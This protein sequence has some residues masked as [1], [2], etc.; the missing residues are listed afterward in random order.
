[1]LCRGPYI[2]PGGSAYGCGQCMPCR[3]NKR[4]EW[5]HRIMLEA[6]QHGDNSF[7]TLTYDDDHL[8]YTSGGLPTLVQDHLT[9]FL[10]RL[11]KAYQPQQLRYFYVGEY[12]TNTQRPHYHLALFNYPACSRGVTQLNR[13]GTCCAVCDGLREIWGA[14]NV[15]S[16]QLENSSA[17][18][19]AGYVVKKFTNPEDKETRDWLQGRKEEF[20]RMS[21][22]PGIGAGFMPEVASV[23]LTHNLDTQ[24]DVP[25]SLRHGSLVRPLGRYLTRQLRSQIG[26]EKNAPK[27]VLEAQKEKMRPLQEAAKAMAP[28]GSYSHTYKTLILEVNEGKYRQLMAKAKRTKKRECL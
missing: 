12:G 19:I 17:A 16:G 7:V 2:A 14:G 18:Y 21:L 11:R 24:T 10:K 6:T 15:Y 1:M 22:K 4:R 25:T 13:R 28:K 9:R 23:L 8:P 20:A 5:T 27:E 3:I 26:R